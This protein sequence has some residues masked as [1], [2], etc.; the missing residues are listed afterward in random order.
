MEEKRDNQ[1]EINIVI[2][3]STKQSY[4]LLFSIL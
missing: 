4:A 1:A 2:L 3:L